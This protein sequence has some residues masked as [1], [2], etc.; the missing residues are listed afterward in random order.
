MCLE[1]PF[2][3]KP[4]HSYLCREVSLCAQSSPEQPGEAPASSTCPNP[5]PASSLY[6]FRSPITP[7][8]LPRVG[9]VGGRGVAQSNYGIRAKCHFLDPHDPLVGQPG[10]GGVGTDDLEVSRITAA[11]AH[12]GFIQNAFSQLYPNLQHAFWEK[13]KSFHKLKHRKRTES[14][15]Y[16]IKFIFDLLEKEFFKSFLLIFHPLE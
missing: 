1:V 12:G 2:W 14:Q 5:P 6:C 13:E 7:A 15:G 11:P 8:C 3:K 4:F 9:A 10:R 16:Q